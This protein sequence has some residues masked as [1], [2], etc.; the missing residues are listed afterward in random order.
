MF[1]NDET[2]DGT[3]EE[4]TSLHID[5]KD[6]LEQ[7]ITMTKRI[8]TVDGRHQTAIS[9]LTLARSSQQTPPIPV[10]LKP[11]F[12][13]ILQGTKKIHAGSHIIY[14][15]PGDFLTSLIDFPASAEVNGAVEP[16][17][18]L[19][20]DFTPEEIAS[21][22]TEA[23]IKVN[24][25]HN[26]LNVGAF[27]G[28]SDAELLG[29][30]IRLLKLIDKPREEILF[31]SKLIKREMI[32]KLLAGNY[33]HLFFQQVFFDQQAEGVGR[34]I[35]WI[36]ENYSRSFTAQEL[37]QANNMSVSGLQHKFKAVTTMGPLQYQKQ[38]RLQ[39]ARRLMLSGAMDA[40]NAALEVGYE[41]TSQFNREYRRLF[42]LPPLQDI[43]SLQKS[44]A[45]DVLKSVLLTPSL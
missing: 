36:K 9:F 5:N 8:A 44:S 3:A 28:K 4:N 39:E 20:V 19:R 42:G 30:F 23:N 40:T 1:T 21:V 13:L 41:S 24:V 14:A 12:C 16:Y 11:A 6:I 26:K 33:G 43:K 29:L 34:A 17:I 22:I 31:L 37:A 38:L 27:I 25:Q 15:R 7:I 2:A 18:G 32:Y 45:A 35:A 10:V